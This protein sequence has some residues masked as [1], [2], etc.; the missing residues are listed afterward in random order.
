MGKVYLISRLAARDLRRRPADAILL[1]LAIATAATALTLGMALHGAADNPYAATRAA[2]SGPDVVAI[3]S[4]AGSGQPKLAD[5]AVLTRLEHASGVT[6]Y[7]GPYPV[8][9]AL[10]RAPGLTAGAEIQGR[11]TG[12]SPVDRPR[13]TSGSWVRPGGVVVEAGFAQALGLRPG[14]QITLGSVAFRIV[15]VAV[16]AAIPN[17]PQVCFLGCDMPGNL[18]NYNPGLV[19]L[20]KTDTERVA[21]LTAAPVA[22]LA[23]LKLKDPAQANAFANA[24]DAS[25]SPAVPYLA[26][27]Q[28]IRD[29]DARAAVLVGGRI[30]GQTRRVGLLKAVGGTPGLVAAVLLAENVL[31]ALGAAGAGLLAG[32]LAAPLLSGPGAGLVGGPGAPSLSA[33]TIGL[34]GAIALDVAIVATF[35]PAIR[36]GRLSTVSA[37]NDAVRPPRRRGPVAAFSAHLPVPLLLGARLAARRP[38]RILLSTL[39]VAVTASGTVAVLVVHATSADQGFLAPNNP[40]NLRMD[41]VTTVVSAMLIVLAAVNAIFIAV[42]TALDARHSSALARALGATRRQTDAALAVVQ[43]FPALAGALLGIPGGI[44]LYAAANNGGSTTVPPAWWLAVMVLA[45]VAV[46]TVLTVIPARIATR[47]PVAEILQAETA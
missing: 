20:T 1:L 4:P 34:V 19:W 18:G 28:A 10:L 43:A 37:L 12:P 39:S 47:R 46:V 7:T 6:A 27:W 38:R 45:T 9:W 36:A 11:S 40:Q 21:R 15:G 44:G 17:Y 2:T 3:E 16:T 30:A 22:Y 41:Q 14:D 8:T 13:L 26:S 25:T 35:L 24:H 31:I 29:Q 33:T 42:T 23:D 5:A 32:W